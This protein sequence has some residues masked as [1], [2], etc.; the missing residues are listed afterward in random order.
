MSLPWSLQGISSWSKQF[1]LSF[2]KKYDFC[3]NVKFREILLKFDMLSI[4]AL[5]LVGTRVKITS[6]NDNMADNNF[7]SLSCKENGC[8]RQN[9]NV[10]KVFN[11][12]IQR[13]PRM[14]KLITT[15]QNE[16]FAATHFFILLYAYWILMLSGDWGRLRYDCTDNVSV[17][18]YLNC[19]SETR[20]VYSSYLHLRFLFSSG[21]AVHWQNNDLIA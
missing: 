9:R 21:A 10:L 1:Q 18:Y 14:T 13:W 5:K 6:S 4:L 16:S 19:K 17:L 11:L 15:C 20:P 3:D 8:Q 7:I 2:F 12:K